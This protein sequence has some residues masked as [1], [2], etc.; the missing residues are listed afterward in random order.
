MKRYTVTI[1]AGVFI[2]LCTVFGWGL[3]NAVKWNNV[4]KPSLPDLS[5]HTLNPR[6]PPSIGGFPWGECVSLRHNCK[7]I[8]YSTPTRNRGFFVSSSSCVPIVTKCHK[9]IA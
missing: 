2:L 1:V 4:Q 7:W 9:F 5:F 3:M 8:F 6:S